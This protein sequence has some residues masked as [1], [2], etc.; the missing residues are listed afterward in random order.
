MMAF[1]NVIAAETV[2]MV[3]H[4]SKKHGELN[5]TNHEAETS[6]T[7][8]NLLGVVH[9]SEKTDTP[10]IAQFPD[11]RLVVCYR[12]QEPT[13]NTYIAES[14][15]GGRNW[16]T[17][18]DL[19]G[20][21]YGPSFFHHDNAT[22]LFLRGKTTGQYNDLLLFK[23]SDHGRNWESTILIK[24]TKQ[25]TRITTG[26]TPV[27]LHDGKLIVA[28]SDWGGKGKLFPE[29]GRIFCGWCPANSDPMV[30]NNW[31]WAKPLEMPDPN[32]APF[33]KGGWLEPN[34]VIAPNGDVLLVTRV[35]SDEG[36]LG[37]IA[38]VN[39]KTKTI[40][41]EDRFPAQP[42]ETGFLR[43]P[44]GGCG[45]FYIKYDPVSKR[46]LMLSNPR[47]G[48][49]VLLWGIKRIRNSL[50]LF[51]SK[52]L[53]HWSW[54][55]SLIKDNLYQDWKTSAVKTGFQQP[56]FVISGDDIIAVSRTAY[57]KTKNWHDAN[58]ITVHKLAD[59]RS[60][61]DFDGMVARYAFD[62]P[63]DLG[64]DTSR[65]GDNDAIVTGAVKSAKGIHGF[66][67]DFKGGHLSLGHRVASELHG[68]SKITI[69]FWMNTQEKTGTI[70]DIPIDKTKNGIGISLIEPGVI[71]VGGRSRS[72]DEFQRVRFP[73]GPVVD[74]WHQVVVTIDYSPHQI[75]LCF[76]GKPIE[77][78][79]KVDFSGKVFERAL[80]S[81]YEVIGK[82]HNTIRPFVGMLD[83]I[84]ISRVK[85][86]D[87]KA[88]RLPL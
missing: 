83:D 12:S 54:V 63:Q 8:D 21:F 39:M 41:F 49:S 88:L 33:D 22:Y 64:K 30:A 50:V 27:L 59:F 11:G 44:G 53:Y 55:K 68:A 26:N 31:N 20:D 15:D 17:I 81:V 6:Y 4:E 2:T 13:S 48:G 60:F 23:S 86:V 70:L 46:Y 56:S 82:S 61:L 18:C 74:A 45:M 10:G 87:A 43:I 1:C 25:T 66:C 29:K 76:D 71:A 42:G 40:E 57:G 35:D 34:A 51:E 16:T 37:A 77:G 72:Q 7:I 24:A 78:S 28:I 79:G 32:N 69:S 80:P 47:L 62:D 19:K 75:S 14:T 73:V 65:Q 9:Q 58:M 36:E 67:A 84:Q 5:M 52:D 3:K 38:K 85:I